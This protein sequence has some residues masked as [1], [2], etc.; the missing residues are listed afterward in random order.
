MR[1]VL[2]RR[3]GQRNGKQFGGRIVFAQPPSNRLT[4]NL[5]QPGPRLIRHIERTTLLDAGLQLR[6]VS[7]RDVLQLLRTQRRQQILIE[8]VANLL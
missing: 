2:R 4:E 8:V 7:P 3:R 5:L 6:A 1:L